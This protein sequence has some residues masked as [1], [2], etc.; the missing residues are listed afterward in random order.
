MNEGALLSGQILELLEKV[1]GVPG[2]TP[3]RQLTLPLQ[4]H[5]DAS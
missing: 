5:H 4:P 2:L 3:E 1:S